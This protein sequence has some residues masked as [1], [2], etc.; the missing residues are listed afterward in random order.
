[1]MFFADYV[2]TDLV[3]LYLV[4][5]TTS[6]DKNAFGFYSQNKIWS[7][8]KLRMVSQGNCLTGLSAQAV[9]LHRVSWKEW[10]SHPFKR[11]IIKSVT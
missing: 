2:Q 10:F 1:M 11:L 3:R 8:V 9:L 4:T 6:L 5:L 7:K